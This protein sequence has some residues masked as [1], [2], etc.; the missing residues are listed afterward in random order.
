MTIIVRSNETGK[1]VAEYVAPTQAQCDAWV[2]E[3]Y[4]I[5]DYTWCYT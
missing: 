1:I 3:R 4:D 5:N 2:A